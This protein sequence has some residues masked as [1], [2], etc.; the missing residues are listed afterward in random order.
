MWKRG[1]GAGKMHGVCHKGTRMDF[2]FSVLEIFRKRQVEATIRTQFEQCQRLGICLGRP[3]ILARHVVALVFND[4]PRLCSGRLKGLALT[5][6]VLVCA[7]M[8]S[9]LAREIRVLCAAALSRVLLAAH[10]EGSLYTH[11]PAEDALLKT[12]QELIRQF[13]DQQQRLSRLMQG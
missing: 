13:N 8:R 12:A 6:T 1:D 3:A 2:L 9:D 5:T 7:F 10:R 11:P 4:R